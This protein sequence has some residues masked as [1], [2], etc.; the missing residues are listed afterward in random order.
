V[1]HDQ[2]VGLVSLRK[3]F[4]FLNFAVSEQSGRVENGTDLKDVRYYGSSG[5]GGQFGQ[6]AKG[7]GRSR[8]RRSA[9]A[10][11]AREDR[12]LRVLLE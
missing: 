2:D 6:F 11:E 12:L 4:Q 9:A 10:F 1:I 3:F 7:L 8:R 5:A